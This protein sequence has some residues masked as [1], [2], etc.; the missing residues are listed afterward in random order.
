MALRSSQ[1]MMSLGLFCALGMTMTVLAV[2]G[3]FGVFYFTAFGLIAFGAATTRLLARRVDLSRIWVRY[4]YSWL[5][6]LLVG[7][8][9]QMIA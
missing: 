9:I 4:F 2:I 6:W 1:S 7:V 3:S 5:L 8:A